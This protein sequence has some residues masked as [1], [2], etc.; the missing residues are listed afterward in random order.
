MTRD[1]W[2][3][4]LG[5]VLAFGGG[6]LG[7]FI[8]WWW[9]RRIQRKVV[10]DFLQELFRAFDR[11]AP[12]VVEA[13][14]KSGVLWNDLLNQ[15]ANDLVMYERNREHSIILSDR[16]LRG[17]VW[18]WFSKA[19][20]VVHM[21]LGLN[22]MLNAAPGHQWATNEVKKQVEKIKELRAE[23]QRLVERLNR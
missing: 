22:A 2:L 15:V 5:A 18:E 19:R 1:L 16:S 21:S 7:F 13:Y 17:D 6:L 10:V 3:V 9:N 8:Q 11:L 14:E 12:R 20:T 4:V 23:A